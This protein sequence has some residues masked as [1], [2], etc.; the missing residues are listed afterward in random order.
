MLIGRPKPDSVPA[1]TAPAIG[2]KLL[3]QPETKNVKS[4]S[5]PAPSPADV[6]AYVKQH[7]LEPAMSLELGGG[8]KLELV[9]KD[10]VK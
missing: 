7:G 6:A 8:V 1:T 5:Q 2:K 10:N 4:E 9:T 3:D